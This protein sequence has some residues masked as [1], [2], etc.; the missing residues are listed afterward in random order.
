MSGVLRIAPVLLP[1]WVTMI[2]GRP[3]SRS[4][5]PFAPLVLSYSST[6]SRTQSLGLGMYSAI[7]LSCCGRL[8]C[9]SPYCSVRGSRITGYDGRIAAFR[10]NRVTSRGDEMRVANKGDEIKVVQ[11]PRPV[12]RT[13]SPSPRHLYLVTGL[14]VALAVTPAVA[15]QYPAKP[16]RI[17]VPIG[18]GGSTDITGRLIAQRLTEQMGVT[19]LVE[20]RPGG[21]AVIGTE[22]AARA[23]ADGY[24]LLAIAVEF[25]INPS[26]RK[27]PYDPLKDFTCVV[28]LTT[29]QYFLS[30]HPAIQV[31]TAKKFNAL[32]TSRPVQV[33]FGSSGSGS[34]NHLAGVVF[35]Q[36]TGTRLVHVPYKSAGQAGIALMSGDIDFMFSSVASVIGHVNSG[37]VRA[38]AT[39]GQKRT[40]VAPDVPTLNELAVPGFVVT[41]YHFLFAPAATP[42]E[43]VA[44]LN[45]EVVKALDS[46]ATKERFASLG[47]EPA[48]GSPAECAKFVRAEIDR[49]GPVVRA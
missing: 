20:N 1:K 9:V 43:V 36:M 5:L 10:A 41:G 44:R 12:T 17:I 27:L 34:A 24:T 4:V 32:A 37:K 35:Q 11:D 15:Q 48:G 31:E 28:Q 3:V 14:V 22:L 42:P 2:T 8:R 30:T 16:V 29:S 45:A 25:T 39:T 38:I 49:W 18:P 26:L 47:L 7:E 21:G 40:P 13:S 23:P 33:T 19:V 46:P 6:C